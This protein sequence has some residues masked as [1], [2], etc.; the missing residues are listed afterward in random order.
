MSA[1]IWSSAQLVYRSPEESDD[2]F[3]A[4]MSQDALSFT[5]AAPFLPIPQG[6]SSGKGSREWISNQLLG[7]L[8]CLPLADGSRSYDPTVPDEPVLDKDGNEKP[9]PKPRPIGFITL[10]AGDPKQAHHRQAEIGVTLAKGFQGKGYGREAIEW[11]LHWGFKFAGLHR[12]GTFFA[13]V[14]L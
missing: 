6:E 2:L 14:L 7:V 10:Q 12:I 3:L 1:T 9:R 8:V 4:Y 13:P 5:Q 11:S